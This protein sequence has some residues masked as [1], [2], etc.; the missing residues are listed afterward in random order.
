MA[1][2]KGAYH[3]ENQKIHQEFQHWFKADYFWLWTVLTR[4]SAC[5]PVAFWVD[6][7]VLHLGHTHT[8]IM[9]NNYGGLHHQMNKNPSL[10]IICTY[11]NRAVTWDMPVMPQE[12]IKSI[13]SY[14]WV[15]I[16]IKYKLKYIWSN[17]VLQ[18]NKKYQISVV[19]LY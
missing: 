3:Q 1:L 6:Q 8:I 15:S 13:L 7:L 11:T 17:E 19:F 9:C 14:Y 2:W 4:V 12:K 10:Q 16:K 18:T 5:V